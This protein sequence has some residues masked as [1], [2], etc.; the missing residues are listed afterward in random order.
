MLGDTRIRISALPKKNVLPNNI[1]F[2]V[3]EAEDIST[4]GGSTFFY[5]LLAV[6]TTYLIRVAHVFSDRLPKVVW[7]KLWLT[8]G[9][10]SGVVC[11]HFKQSFKSK[12]Q[13]Q[14][15]K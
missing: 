14:A 11:V 4:T 13:V 15:L 10:R 3:Y 8:P 7:V 5:G 9:P 2:H 1:P 6:N 12:Y